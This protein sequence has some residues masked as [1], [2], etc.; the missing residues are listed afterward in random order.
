MSEQDKVLQF[1]KTNYG[2]KKLP[3]AD[4][5]LRIGQHGSYATLDTGT[6]NGQITVVGVRFDRSEYELRDFEDR[7]SR[8]KTFDELKAALASHLD[9]ITGDRLE[10]AFNQSASRSRRR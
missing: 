7:T 1:L 6:W 3:H 5:Q 9:A 8:Y 2:D 4:N 10:Q